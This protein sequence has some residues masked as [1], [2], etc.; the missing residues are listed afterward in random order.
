MA[1][2]KRDL[3]AEGG[4]EV[5]IFGKKRILFYR[6]RGISAIERGMREAG[7]QLGLASF[8]HAASTET[9]TILCLW[10][11]LLHYDDFTDSLDDFADRLL[12]DFDESERNIA[13]Y[14]N[15]VVEC[16]GK[17]I[18]RVKTKKSLTNNFDS[19]SKED[20]LASAD[21]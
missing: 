8:F 19:E 7:Y 16:V 11:G 6:Y 2:N 5:E 9:L 21:S 20:P 17:Q 10:A 14:A 18:I 1:E 15:T 12:Y 13:D 3:L 4:M